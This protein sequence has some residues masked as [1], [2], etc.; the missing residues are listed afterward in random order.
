MQMISTIV[1][2]GAIV[3]LGVGSAHG[4]DAQ[5]EKTII[6]NERAVLANAE[7]L[8]GDA[9]AALQAL[10]PDDDDAGAASLLRSALQHVQRIAEVDASTAELSERINEVVV[11][12][13]DVASDLRR[14]VESVDAD[15][16]RLASV[17]ERFDLIQKLKRKYGATIPEIQA[18]MEAAQAEL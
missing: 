6:A 13:D 10:E 3:A 18:H 8:I 2:A 11:L 12:A 15:P 14:Y 1:L 17:E 16:A 7:R 5:T 4:Q 9:A